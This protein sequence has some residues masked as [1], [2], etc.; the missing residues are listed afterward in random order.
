MKPIHLLLAVGMVPLTILA[1]P[2]S[3]FVTIR[4]GHLSLDGVRQRYWAA[5]GK[6]FLAP[7]IKPDDSPERRKEKIRDAR[8]GTDVIVQR[9][10]D[11]GFNATRLW[12]TVPNTEDYTPGDGSPADS[13]DYFIAKMKENGLKIWCAG[14]NRTG[15][16]LPGDV[17]IVDDPNTAKAWSDAVAAWDKKGAPLGRNL[18][19]AWD[20]R[21]E[22]LALRD[23]K[24]V[25]THTNKHTGLRWCDDPVFVV[26][27]LSNEEWWMR[28]MLA[29]Q[30]Q[31]L[32]PFFKNQLV[33]KWNGWLK[34]KYAGDAKLKT[35]WNALLPGESL[36]KGSVLFAPMA[37]PTASATSLNDDSEAA[38]L[39][40]EGLKQ[41]YARADFAPQRA[42]DVLEFLLSLQIA[43]KERE[44]AAV[45]SWGR[46]TKL[47]PLVYDTGIGY[48]I[49]S[50]YLH[51]H[52]DAVAHDA[53]VNGNYSQ[54]PKPDPA[55]ATDLQKM[56]SALE[57][58]RKQVNSGP[59]V[60]WLL[61]PPGISQGVPWLEHNRIEG[62]PFFCYETQIQ[63]PAKYRAD[64]PLRLAALASIQDWD[65]VC[66]HYFAPGGD[67]GTAER[68]FDKPMDIS[69][70]S[71]P[72]GYHFTFDEVQSAMMRAAGWMWR[73]KAFAPAAAPTKF[74]YGRKSLHDPASMDYGGSY[75]TTGMDMNLT[76]YQHGMRIS[77]DPTREDD[78]VI[79]PVVKFADRG[80]HNPYT[81]TPEILFDW[82]KGFL[83]MDAPDGVAWT[84]VFGKTGGEVKFHNGVTL[85]DVKIENPPGIFEPMGDDEKYLAFALYST[86]GL[87]LEKC[88][89]A[90]LSLVSTSFNSG[91]KLPEKEG[92]KIIAG[93]LPV[94]VARVGGTIQA[95]ALEG[96]TYTL[97]DWHMQ[98]IGTGKVTGG[99]LV[100]PSDKPVFVADLA[101]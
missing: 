51:Q 35:A 4:D 55:D 42:S 39:S 85:R 21:L 41:E 10:I 91:F 88:K 80:T 16:A 101:R 54:T 7:E 13:V 8:K 11:L 68:P 63:Q 31:K 52:A 86:D 95:P 72:Q 5:I 33:A 69:T 96:M 71:H 59:W 66:W 43:H 40:L 53:Y 84:G 17:A 89:K 28:K 78:E 46:S 64:F 76:T 62:K 20:P 9:L 50:Q 27:E 29:G 98:P 12:A 14:M 100:I 34:N 19:R 73:N 15:V 24:A 38:R 94:L 81:P 25:A 97:R 23:M 82:K 1:A 57:A 2:N 83:N 37:G 75:G 48:E 74:I 32:P 6:V 18:A 44:A 99:K 60:N 56:Q 61:K 92:E 49:Q 3:Q 70:G 26:W 22:A 87:P 36:E 58:E 47:S 77:I 90:S 45:K 79:G 65:F 93:T 30:W 67:S